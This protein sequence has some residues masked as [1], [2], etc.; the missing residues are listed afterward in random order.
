M[1]CTSPVLISVPGYYPGLFVPCGKCM[2]CRVAYAREWATRLLHEKSYWDKSVFLTL[3][4]S[5][6]N[7]PANFSVEKAALQKF[8]KR[9][10]KSLGERK[11]KYFACGEYGDTSDRPHYHAIV[12]GLGLDVEDKIHVIESWPFCDWSVPVILQK[13]FG[14]VT[15]DSCRYV[16]EYVLKKYNNSL[17]DEVYISKGREVPFRLM[18]LG[19][20]KRFAV[21]NERYLREQLGCTVRGKQVGLPRYYRNV[22][23]ITSEELA[24]RAKEH[25]AKLFDYYSERPIKRKYIKPKDLAEA[26]SDES[27]TPVEVTQ[28]LVDIPESLRRARRQAD[29]NINARKN[30]FKKKL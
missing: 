20:G 21:D 28:E 5:D 12:F 10:R 15:Y 22:L 30:L 23:E 18:S 26:A 24:V 16:C 29:K 27:V 14:N 13:S 19:L 11:I 2:S 7:L 17:A 6:D 8:F 4:Y 3:T 25:E 1:Q 9:L